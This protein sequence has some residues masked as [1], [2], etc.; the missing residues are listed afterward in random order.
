[1]RGF[2]G[3]IDSSLA[4]LVAFTPLSTCAHVLPPSFER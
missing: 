2:V 1:M 3:S 4:P